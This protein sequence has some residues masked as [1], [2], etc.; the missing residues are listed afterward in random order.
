MRDVLKSL[1]IPV[2]SICLVVACKPAQKTKQTTGYIEGLYTYI[3]PNFSGVIEKLHVR[4]GH[5][6]QEGQILFTLE[7]QPQISQLKVAEE[8]LAQAIAAKEEVKARLEFISSTKKRYETLA[9]RNAIEKINLDQEDAKFDEANAQ[10]AAAEANIA[11]KTA[12]LA[13]T[14]WMLDRKTV[15]A[16]VDGLIFDIFYRKGEF[17]LPEKPVMAILTPEN[18]KA[19][20]YIP[21][22]DLA[23]IHLNGKIK[24]GCDGCVNVYLA[25]ISY[26]SPTAE[27]TP[28]VIYSTQTNAALVFRVEAELSS[29]SALRLHPGQPI[30]VTYEF[31]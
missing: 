25:N 1:I 8:S 12:G 13:E 21:E 31:S 9:T 2:L 29:R 24:I 14:S 7:T 6:V 17:A 15:K 18:V 5:I 4:K 20:F 19:I 23:K 22:P 3:S 11:A 10:L 26:I 30:Y 27:Y 16:P 28:P